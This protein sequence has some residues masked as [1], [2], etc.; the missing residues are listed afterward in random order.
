MHYRKPLP[1]ISSPARSLDQNLAKNGLAYLIEKEQALMHL[2]SAFAAQERLSNS[3]HGQLL[4]AREQLSTPTGARRYLRAAVR[5]CRGLLHRVRRFLHQT[6]CLLHPAKVSSGGSADPAFPFEAM[7]GEQLP[8]LP[9]ESPDR[10]LL[11]AILA[12]PPPGP[13]LAGKRVDI[14]VPVY[15]GL[16]ET[17]LCLRSVLAARTTVPYELIVLND[18]SPDPAL[19]SCLRQIARRGLITLHENAT[20]LGFVKTTN[21]GLRLHPERD[22]VLLNSDTEVVNDWLG[23]LRE[24]A[25]SAR[26]IG[27]VTPLSNNATICSYPKFV[28][29]NPLPDG[30]SLEDL[31][32]LCSACNRGGYVAIPT[33]VGFCMYLRRDCLDMVGLLNEELF[34]KGYGEEN[35]FCLRAILSGWRHLLTTDTFVFHRG[36]TSF[37]A[38][39]QPAVERALEVLATL[40]PEYNGLIAGHM[41]GNPALPFRRRLDLARVAGAPPALR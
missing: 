17:L 6:S 31:D 8:D 20:N 15:K 33:G 28:S 34:G 5:R 13:V 26:D 1:V 19:S 21:R 2:H 4:A 25:Y 32:Q 23:R 16:R 41:R 22:A 35:D 39:R 3:L 27:S 12:S 24:A 36:A 10:L 30:L 11:N 29:D 37:G 38:S 7:P 9:L 40:Y 18:A 14:I